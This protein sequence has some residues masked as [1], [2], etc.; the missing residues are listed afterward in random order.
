MRIGDV[1]ARIGARD[2]DVAHGQ[3]R[4]ELGVE[5]GRGPVAGDLVLVRWG[6]EVELVLD[7]DGLV[8]RR[9]GVELVEQQREE[10][11]AHLRRGLGPAEHRNDRGRA[12]TP[13]RDLL[14]A[15]E[16]GLRS[17]DLGR[18]P[19]RPHGEVGGRHLAQNSAGR[20]DERVEVGS[21][22]RRREVCAEIQ[23]A[24]HHVRDVPDARDHAL[25]RVLLPARGGLLVRPRVRPA[26]AGSKKR[27]RHR[28]Q[29]RLDVPH[30]NR[31]ARAEQQTSIFDAALDRGRVACL[32]HT[33]RRMGFQ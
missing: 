19:L 20:C 17:E 12:G 22:D 2:D 6:L 30:V 24:G 29:N 15:D 13:E 25:Q 9:A 5:D 10:V 26:A 16:I 32:E 3:A 18:K 11:V 23:V 28:H 4:V 33:R 8:L 1:N 31:P 7:G 14:Q 27:D 21:A